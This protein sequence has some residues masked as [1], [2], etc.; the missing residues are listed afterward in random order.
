MYIEMT[1]FAIPAFLLTG[2]KF[3]GLV[4]CSWL[5]LVFIGLAIYQWSNK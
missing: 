4:F 5:I 1:T 3:A 2:L